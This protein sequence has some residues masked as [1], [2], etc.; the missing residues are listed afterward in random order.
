MRDFAGDQ[1]APPQ[2]GRYVGES[3]VTYAPDGSLIALPSR[4]KDPLGL[5]LIA[6]AG[7]LL[8]LGLASVVKSRVG[9]GD[10][11]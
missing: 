11:E 1:V 7:A 9:R 8:T 2:H 3:A 4:V 6:G 5:S 10:L